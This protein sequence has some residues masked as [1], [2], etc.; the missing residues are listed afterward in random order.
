MKMA[1]KVFISH[2]TRDRG[3]VI[4]LANLFTKFGVEV[5]VAEWY[6]TP[7]EPLDK[8]VFAQIEKADCIVILLTKNGLRSNWIQQEI[9]YAIKN[10]KP[11]IPLV[12]K[13]TDPRDL[14]ALQSKEYIEYDPFK[15]EQALLRA[16]TYVKS[17]KLRKAEQEKTLLVAGGILALVLLLS[18]SGGEK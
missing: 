14:A 6:L 13:G 2:S 10:R 7:G 5:F 17:L 18:L 4:A 16:S 8:K 15:P 3:L 1:Y 12:E 9:G 11:L